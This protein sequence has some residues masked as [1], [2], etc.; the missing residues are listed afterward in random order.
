MYWTFILS[1]LVRLLAEVTN[2]L[3]DLLTTEVRS[4]KTPDQRD[5]VKALK[6]LVDKALGADGGS[7]KS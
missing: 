3:L 7:S 4:F 5:V 2:K 1:R 6:E